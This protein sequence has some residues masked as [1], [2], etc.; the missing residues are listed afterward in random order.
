MVLH[1]LAFLKILV[2]SV[3][4][5][6]GTFWRELKDWGCPASLMISDMTKKQQDHVGHWTQVV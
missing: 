5:A 1:H 6:L 3:K 4:G 2:D